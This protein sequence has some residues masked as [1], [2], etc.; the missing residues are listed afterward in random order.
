MRRLATGVSILM[1][2]LVAPGALR[3]QAS[4]YPAKPIRLVVPFPAGGPADFIGRALANTLRPLL[5]QTVVIDDRGGASGIAGTDNVAKSRPDGYSLLISSPGS[6]AIAPSIADSMPY[7]PLR[8]LAPISL[9]VTVPEVLVAIPKLGVRTLPEFVAYAK[10][11]P[12]GLN[13]ASS[14]SGSMPH[15]AGELLTREAGI[16]AVHVPYRGAAPAVN[17]LLGGQV[18]F[19]FADIPIL[20]PY[21]QSGQL[22]GLALGSAHRAPA[23]PDLPTTAE[24]GYP[25][26]L[27]DNWYGLFAPAGTPREIIQTLNQ[28][29]VAALK[30]PALRDLLAKQGA[31]AAGGSPEALGAFLR[32]ETNKWGSLAKDVGARLD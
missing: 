2:L 23:L 14:G 6:L 9:V 26:A 27:A 16:K 29:V 3:A 4:L 17:D 32:S 7:D 28:A 25:N 21:L 20:M 30:D 10:A 12:G 5:N 8:D 31:Q 1:A 15:L 24:A 19:M 18:D 13:M 22:I 11:H